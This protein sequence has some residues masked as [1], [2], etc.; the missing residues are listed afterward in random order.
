MDHTTRPTYYASLINNRPV[1]WAPDKRDLTS[2]N[3]RTTHKRRNL[4]DAIN[5]A[6]DVNKAG[7]LDGD[8]DDTIY[9]GFVGN[10]NHAA[11]A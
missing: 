8:F 11:D 5:N 6:K 3:Q 4:T 1:T 10:H 9:V 2:E 7:D